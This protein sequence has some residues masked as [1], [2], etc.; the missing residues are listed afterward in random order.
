MLIY[1]LT[2]LINFDHSVEVES[3]RFLFYTSTVFFF[4]C[5]FK[6]FKL[7]DS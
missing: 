4:I 3:A 2:S 5:Y 6:H 7:K 1:P